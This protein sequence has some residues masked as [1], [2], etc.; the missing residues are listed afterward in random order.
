MKLSLL[1]RFRVCMAIV[2]FVA[3]AFLFLDLWDTG[4]STVAGELLFLQVVP[5]L[6]N[7]L[8]HGA[9][10]AAGFMAVLVIT[11]LLGRVYCSAVCPMGIFQDIIARLF[12]KKPSLGKQR[13]KYAFSPPF[14]ILRHTLL[15]LTILTFMLGSGL[16]LN[17]LDPFSSLGRILAHIF[18]PIAVALNN[19]M[20]PAA[21]VL[22]I[23]ALFLVQ[24]PVP[25]PVSLGVALAALGLLGWMSARHGRLYCNTICP[26]GT[27]LGLVSKISLVRIGINTD[28]CKS[29]GQCMR[30]CK[31]GCIDVKTKQ[32]DISRCVGCFNCL[33]ACPDQAMTYRPGPQAAKR[34]GSAPAGRRGFMIALA[35]GAAGMASTR[36]SAQTGPLP[37][38]ERPTTIPEKRTCPISPPG[39][40]GIDRY[41]AICTACHLCVSA[42]PSRVLVPSIFSFGLSGIMQPRMDFSSGH[43]N[44]DCTVCSQVCPTNAIRPLSTQK[45]RETQVGVA[46]FIKEN[47][48]VFTDRTNCGACSEHCPTKAV[49][50]VPY[51]TVSGR[52][53]VI[54][55]VTEALCVGCGGC[56]HACPT[57]PYKAIY[58]DGNPVHRV[59]DK[60]VEQKL[61]ADTGKDFPF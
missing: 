46:K 60:P 11:L 42:C 45:K 5:S 49:H 51:L 23:H 9:A 31:A 29:C 7:F 53:L 58:V 54:P 28:A 19:L 10:D 39:S 2:F 20:V 14:T 8:N 34:N 44:Y 3:T 18:R 22:G 26:V 6:L 1:K 32:V 25:A 21:E 61:D 40:A 33:S 38:Q 24:W 48:V 16:I 50:M 17:L 47:C 36:L 37:V 57:R 35:A 41:T 55:Q 4:V 13:Y 27:L 56:E 59:A 52:K 15:C 43:C 30:V 12:S